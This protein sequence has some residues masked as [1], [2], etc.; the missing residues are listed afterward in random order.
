MLAHLRTPVIAS[1]TPPKWLREILLSA[2]IAAR[3][4]AVFAAAV[5]FGVLVVIKV[6]EDNLWIAA[7]IAAGVLLLVVLPVRLWWITRSSR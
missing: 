2:G 6:G 7:V 5:A 4:I 1:F 3:A